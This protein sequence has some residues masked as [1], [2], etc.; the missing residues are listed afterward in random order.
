MNDLLHVTFHLRF[1]PFSLNVQLD[2]MMI[3]WMTETIHVYIYIHTHI[4][5]MILY[6]H[7]NMVHHME[8]IPICIYDT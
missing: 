1:I 3:E 7:A 6:Q 8:H 2:G 5:Y 4:Y